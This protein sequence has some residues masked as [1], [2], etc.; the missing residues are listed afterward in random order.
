MFVIRVCVKTNEMRQLLFESKLA[1]IL[2]VIIVIHHTVV[3]FF[4]AK[5]LVVALQVLKNVLKLVRGVALEEDG[6]LA[7]QVG[8]AC[9]LPNHFIDL[10]LCEWV[11][12]ERLSSCGTSLLALLSAM[13]PG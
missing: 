3:G 5:A 11:I 8:D 4:F 6:R 13:S 2:W 7:V 10:H 12:F 1:H 9:V